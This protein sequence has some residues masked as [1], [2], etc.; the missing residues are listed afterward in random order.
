[1]DKFG[2]NAGVRV[3][4]AFEKGKSLGRAMIKYRDYQGVKH[5]RNNC[6]NIQV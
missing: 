4:A 3:I 5:E 2:I 1:M 6:K